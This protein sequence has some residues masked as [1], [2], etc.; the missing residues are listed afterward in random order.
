[1]Q[2][3]TAQPAPQPSQLH[4]HVLLCTAIS[5]MVSVAEILKKDKLADEKRESFWELCHVWLLSVLQ[6]CIERALSHETS[7]P[8]PL[9]SCPHT[10][11]PPLRMAVLSPTWRF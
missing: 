1:M 11:T 7:L 9:Q 5:T 10:W 2:I 6:S 3:C 4:V 8:V